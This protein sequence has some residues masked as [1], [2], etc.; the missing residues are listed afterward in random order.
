MNKPSIPPDWFDPTIISIVGV[1][2]Q[3]AAIVV[4]VWIIFLQ[5]KR[6]HQSSLYL[7]KR[8]FQ[9]ELHLK[10]FNKISEKIESASNAINS[11]ISD[12]HGLPGSIKLF[13]D[14]RIKENI[15]IKP[16]MKRSNE[17]IT[18]H[19]ST[20]NS[21]FKLVSI[22]ESHEIAFPSF[23]I[24]IDMIC[25]QNKVCA[26]EF[27]KFFDEVLP[28]LPIDVKVKNQKI[29]GTDVIKPR[30]PTTKILKKIRCLADVYMR[31]CLT[32][33]SYIYDLN[34]EGQNFLLGNLFDNRIPVRKPQDP[35][36]MVIT[37]DQKNV[38]ELEKYL[39]KKSE[40][41]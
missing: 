32:L 29:L 13:W 17:I 12:V 3:L 33:Q 18:S 10:I 26:D 6:N 39:K 23:R 19:R 30:K 9:E 11:S 15:N 4:G 14:I 41:K 37:T 20:Q 34:I 40:R 5:V 22:I 38:Q 8:N 16:Y 7:Q 1:I 27:N 25:Y 31:E 36:L 28:Y 2:I 35:K 24:F 21:V